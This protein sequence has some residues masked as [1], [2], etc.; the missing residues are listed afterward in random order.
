MAKDV[1]IRTLRPLNAETQL[2]RQQGLLTSVECFYVRNHFSIPESWPGLVVDGAVERRLELGINDIRRMPRQTLTVTLECAG[3][4]RAFQRPQAEGVQWGIGAVGTAEFTGTLLSPLL[5]RAR[6]KPGAI[7]VLFVGADQGVP[8]RQSNDEEAEPIHFA[9]SLPLEDALNADVL[10]AYEMNGQPLWAEHGAP[11]RLIVPRRYAVAAVKWLVRVS[12][13]AS[14]FHGYYQATHY[15][16]EDGTHEPEPLGRIAVRSIITAPEVGAKLEKGQACTIRGYSW[17]GIAPV[18][19][20]EVSTN[21]GRA[22]LRAEVSAAASDYEWVEWQATWT[23]TAAGTYRLM[24]RATDA[25]HNRQP[26]QARWNRLGYA[27]NSVVPI[28]ISVR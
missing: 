1:N 4:G 2:H 13:L 5:K 20:V 6:I 22:W 9:R 12:V 28:A 18:T 16:F 3:N 25:A 26:R 23:P 17:S 10:L 24:A 14:R 7:E 11:L 21:G 15:V 8:E 19:R 27:N